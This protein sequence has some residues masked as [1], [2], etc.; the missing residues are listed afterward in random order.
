MQKNK[1]S[2]RTPHVPIPFD[3]TAFLQKIRDVITSRKYFRMRV[4][5]NHSSITLPE[6]IKMLNII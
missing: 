2:V 6:N 5:N 3:M 4:K 1:N